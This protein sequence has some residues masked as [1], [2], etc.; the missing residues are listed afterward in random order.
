MGT[1]AKHA[2]ET[3]EPADRTQRRGVPR[4]PRRGHINI[5][6]AATRQEAPAALAPSGPSAGGWE[7]LVTRSPNPTSVGA[8]RPR[9][10]EGGN[11]V[12]GRPGGGERSAGRVGAREAESPWPVDGVARSARPWCTGVQ[13]GETCGRNFLPRERK[14]RKK[15]GRD[16][17]C[18]SNFK[19]TPNTPS[20]DE[21]S[22]G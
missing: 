4:R 2:C 7:K 19:N 11:S 3:G 5:L 6:G 15:A 22:R 12:P 18:L 8:R 16:L 20:G 21:V 17:K 14:S 13:R 10:G 9:N 1:D